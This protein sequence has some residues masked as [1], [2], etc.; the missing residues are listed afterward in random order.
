MNRT[1]IRHLFVCC[2]LIALGGCQLLGNLH[3][4]RNSHDRANSAEVAITSGA[5]VAE[6]RTHLREGRAG[7]AIEAFNRALASGQDPAASFN[8]LGVAYARLG[9]TDLAFR[10]FKKATLS[11]PENA[12]YARNLIRLVDSPQFA[13][14]MMSQ[15]AP[16]AAVT[17]PA[18]PAAQ[19]RAA[20]IPGQLQR[21]GNRQFTLT[22][23]PPVDAVNGTAR[24]TAAAADCPRG[25]TRV[26]RPCAAVAL[27]RVASRRP[28][29]VAIA[30][31]S[32]NPALGSAATAAPV[33]PAAAVASPDGQRRII[34]FGQPP[35]PAVQPRNRAS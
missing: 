18:L 24:R 22:T 23:L 8:G 25:K 31:P 27:P 19:V 9:R 5:V 30:V 11:E 33:E 1:G 3:L 6:G 16:V 2:S 26:V 10:F 17:S 13:L 12:A 15:A 34:K 14:A 4:T 20:L 7:L 29:E 28:A 32:A 21:D 35:T